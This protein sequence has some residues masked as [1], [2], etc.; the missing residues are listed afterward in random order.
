MILQA[1]FYCPSCKK[2][3]YRECRPKQRVV[4]ERCENAGRVV[5]MRRRVVKA[6][7][8]HKHVLVRSPF[9]GISRCACGYS[10]EKSVAEPS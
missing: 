4:R 2:W 8:E 3:I 6:A 10:P 5:K 7:S 9:S 1:E